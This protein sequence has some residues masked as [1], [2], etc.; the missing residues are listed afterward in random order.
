MLNLIHEVDLLQ[1]LLGPITYVS[2]LPTTKTRAFEAE[3]GAAILLRF[4]SGVVGTFILSDNTPS[5]WNFEGGTGENPMIPKVKADESAGGFYRILGQRGSLSVPDLTR[6]EGRWNEG[7]SREELDVEKEKVPF[8]AQVQHFVEVVRDGKTPSCT[9][10]EGLRAMVVCE[11]VK[12]S[13]KRNGEGIEIRGL[14][15]VE[16]Q[17]TR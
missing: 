5:P 9:S 3:E 13:M 7:L 12:R 14:Q 8:D 16:K 11:T 15:I 10:E 17:T 1:Y 4:E 6:W 2:A